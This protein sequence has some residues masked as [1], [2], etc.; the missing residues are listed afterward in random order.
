MV[1]EVLRDAKDPMSMRAI[2]IQMLAHKGHMMPDKETRERTFY[3][4]STTLSVLRGRGKVEMFGSWR[5][6]TWGIAK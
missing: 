6:F 3:R 5:D 4:A 2:A 1:L